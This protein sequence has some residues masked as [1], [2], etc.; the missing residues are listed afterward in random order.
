VKAVTLLVVLLLFWL[1]LVLLHAGIE[2]EVNAITH[3]SRTLK[4]FFCIVVSIAGVSA[5]T[6]G[7]MVRVLVQAKYKQES[8]R[9][10]GVARML[11]NSIERIQAISELKDLIKQGE[12]LLTDD[13]VQQRESE[14][15]K[16]VIVVSVDLFF[17]QQEQWLTVIARNLARRNGPLYEYFV[18]DDAANRDEERNIRRKLIGHLSQAGIDNAEQILKSQFQICYLSKEKFPHPIFNGFAIYRNFDPA[19]DFC[20]LY[21]PREQWKWNVDLLAGKDEIKKK[22][23]I[24]ALAEAEQQLESLREQCHQARI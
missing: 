7:F 17:E 1:S 22:E 12:Y 15:D 8:I 9:L 5:I 21:F 10:R 11:E 19:K 20:L 23:A 14:T 13:Q 18:R 6:C 4:G 24:Q 16:K 2:H 3:D